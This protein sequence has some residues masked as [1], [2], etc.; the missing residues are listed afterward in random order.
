MSKFGAKTRALE[1]VEGLDLS[2]KDYIVT[3][4]TSGIGV[5][6]V[7]A[8]AKAGARVTMAV[9]DTKKGDEVARKI[10]EVTSDHIH[11]EVEKVHLDSLESVNDFVKRFLEKKIPLHGLINNAGIMACPKT[12]TIDGFEAQFGTNHMGHFALTLGLIPAL[13]EGYKQSGKKSRVI[14]VSS[15]THADAE[16]NFDDVNYRNR[17]YDPWKAYA[18]SK[19]ANIL[20]SV[21]LTELYSKDGIV[22]NAVMPGAIKTGLQRH[23]PED[24]QEKEGWFDPNGFM[25]SL[26]KT[27]E[28]GAKTI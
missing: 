1:V 26:L 21:A 12:Y 7:R 9:R 13:I 25:K 2:K 4:A 28:Q 11:V 15:I 3:G 14:N 27:S 20:F 23:I 5:E 19:V 17:D 22:S 10:R 8:L 16:I 18:Q 6:T 24:V